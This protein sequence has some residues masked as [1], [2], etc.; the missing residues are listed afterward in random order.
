MKSLLGEVYV[1]LADLMALPDVGHNYRQ[2]LREV[3]EAARGSEQAGHP[4]SLLPILACQAAGGD[5]ELAI[6][7]AA[8]W[9][10]LH[11]AAKLL[12]DVEDGDVDRISTSS[13]NPPRVIN[14]A[15][16]FIMIANLALARV[17]ASGNDHLWR[18]L[19]FDF[20]HTVLRMASG[21]HTD[22]GSHTAF[23]VEE[24]FRIIAAKSGAF[25]A[26][27]ARAGA[28]CAT[29]QPDLLARYDHFGYNVGI[30]IQLADD[31]H[32]FRQ[33]GRQGDLAA[34]RRTLPVLYALAVTPPPQRAYLES[35]LTRAP[36]DAAAEAAAR[37]LIVALGGEVYLQAEIIRYY[38]RAWAALESFK[39]VDFASKPLYDWLICLIG[40]ENSACAKLANR[41]SP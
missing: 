28:H 25:F 27:A 6:P 17:A 15:T 4:L 21:Q 2:L 35:L 39:E 34:G 33:S 32:G 16:G 22:L 13:I 36:T 20:S 19:H 5:P 1:L 38:R 41:T 9:R 30:L 40:G 37:H 11:I 24:Y 3:L 29:E 12:D 23:D 10:A 8:A 26:L 14:L 18:V 7:V 31:L